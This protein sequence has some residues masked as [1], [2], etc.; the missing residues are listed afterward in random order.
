MSYI[1]RI[2]LVI[3]ICFSATTISAQPINWD[4]VRAA[5]VTKYQPQQIPAWLF[6]II[7]E[8]GTGQRDTIYLGYDDNALKYGIPSKDTIFGE[9]YLPLDTSKFQVVW[10]EI[11]GDKGIKVIVTPDSNFIGA[12]IQNYHSKFNLKMYWDKSLYYSD[13]LPFY[14]DSLNYPDSLPKGLGDV[15]CDNVDPYYDNCMIAAQFPPFII[16][17]DPEGY[18]SDSH[19]EICDF[20]PPNLSDPWYAGASPCI[21]TDSIVIFGDTSFQASTSPALMRLRFLVWKYASQAIGI[22]ANKLPNPGV[23]I[24]P[25]PLHFFTTIILNGFSM[26]SDLTLEV[27]DLYGRQVKSKFINSK[28][29]YFYRGDL[30][31]GIYLYILADGGNVLRTGKL[32]IQ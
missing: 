12:G 30:P 19:F 24:N 14:R 23:H 6:P 3:L 26:G 13:S 7:F 2:F 4:S 27:Y 1:A 28:T 15:E 11:L 10:E 17:A 9:K 22:N 18:F 21:A 16:P 5:Y 29:T 25:N 32:I 8:E 20:R 31:N